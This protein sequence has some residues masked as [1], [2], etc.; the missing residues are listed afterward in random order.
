MKDFVIFADSACDLP[1]NIIDELD[2]KYLGIVCTLNGVEYIEDCGQTLKHKDF[3]KAVR[4]GA[5]PTTAQINNFRF[6]ESFED[7]VKEGKSILY[8]C[9]SSALSG[10]Y[11][12]AFIAKNEILE[13]YPSAD[14]NIID[15]K[16][17]SGGL[18]LLVYYA[19]LMKKQGKPIEEIIDWVENNKL[20]VCHFFTV[21][22]LDHLKRGGRISA[23][24]ATIGGL[25]N[26][27]PVMHVNDNGELKN[28]VKAKGRKKAIKTLFESFEKHIL[29]PEEQ[30]I[31]INHGDCIDD[32][33]TLANMIREKYVVKDIVIHYLGPVI[34][35]HTGADL[36]TLFFMGDTRSIEN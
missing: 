2:I 33:E 20:K 13:K 12:S 36:L 32:A 27:K 21:N 34:G 23:T 22:D 4:E 1:L 24:A 29:N 31:I 16:S 11:Q 6:Q 19:G 8:I 7:Y 15:S 26:I 35:S 14:I 9:F 28:F 3:F 10:T 30:T 25:L 18:G 17:A 5:L